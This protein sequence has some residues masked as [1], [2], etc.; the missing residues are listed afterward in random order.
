MG[1]AALLGGRASER[2]GAI[3]QEHAER[4]DPH[5][6]AVARVR[7]RRAGVAPIRPVDQPPRRAPGALPRAHLPAVMHEGGQARRE[8]RRT[9]AAGVAHDCTSSSRASWVSSV[10]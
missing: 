1:N 4:R 3:G 2:R 9:P 5:R 10:Y 7:R 6:A 8:G